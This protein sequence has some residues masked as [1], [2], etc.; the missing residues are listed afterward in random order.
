[1]LTTDEGLYTVKQV[2]ALTGVLET[3]LRV[4]ERR[5]QVVTPQRSTGGY[6]LYD[7]NQ[8]AR[9]R[10][11]AALVADGVPASVAAKTLPPPGVPEGPPQPLDD[12]DLVETARRLDAGRLDSLLAEALARAP[13]E[14]VVDD[15]L[16]PELARL[17]REWAAGE[18]GVAHEHFVTAGVIRAL[19]RAFAESPD[20]GNGAPVLVGMGTGA[21]HELGLLAFAACLRRAGASVV[22][23]GADVPVA[24]WVSAAVGLHPRG[25]VIGVPLGSPVRHAQ[26][27][28][29][30]L[31]ELTP[32]VAIWV[33]GGLA[34]RLK[35][36]DQ[37]PAGVAVA[38]SEVA[39]SLRSG[40]APAPAAEHITHTP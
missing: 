24:D 25:A 17:G 40:R 2:A 11:M 8:V 5:Y 23:L 37:L 3:T 27:I 15:W 35:G 33:G 36:V 21:H 12:L 14:H 19:G 10:T 20:P 38:A 18:I 7:E 30:R 29:D 13:L 9:L 28:V 6:R 34:G 31:R 32:P 4:W 26:E 39:T 1:M 16:L 22:Y